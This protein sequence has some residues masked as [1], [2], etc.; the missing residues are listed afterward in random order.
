MQ[1]GWLAPHAEL[2]A[3][4]DGAQRTAAGRMQACV[5]RRGASSHLAERGHKLEQCGA[6]DQ[7]R[8]LVRL[9]AKGLQAAGG[10]GWGGGGAQVGGASEA[11]DAQQRHKEHGQAAAG[12]AAN[13]PMSPR[14]HLS[15]KAEVPSDVASSAPLYFLLALVSLAA[16]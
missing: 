16:L 10:A 4:G 5:A 7:A 12:R 11:P 14:P 3:C 15:A 9:P 6:A 1:G 2:A 13:A 8:L